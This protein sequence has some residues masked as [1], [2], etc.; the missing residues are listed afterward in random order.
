MD[1][2]TVVH[3]YD[4]ILFS[5]K[6]EMSYYTIKKHGRILN[7]YY[8]W[9]KSVCKGYI[10]CDSNHMT[11]QKQ[12]YGKTMDRVKRWVV[13]MDFGGRQE[14]EGWK[15]G[16]QDFMVMKLLSMIL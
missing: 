8:K 2:Q 9:M 1:K 3:P 13:V 10:L 16:I 15:G 12:Y 4:G 11:L 5:N 6:K 7:A 14:K